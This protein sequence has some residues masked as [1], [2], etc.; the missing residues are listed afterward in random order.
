MAENTQSVF[1]QHAFSGLTLCAIIKNHQDMFDDL[2]SSISTILNERIVSPLFGTLFFTWSVWNWKIIYFTLF[3]SEEKFKEDKITYITSNF[4]EPEFL[5]IYPIIS[6]VIILTIIPFISNGTYWLSLLFNRWRVNKKNEVLKSQL[7]TL[8]Q[9]IALREEINKREK[10]FEEL[11]EDKNSQI[12]IL[13]LELNTLKNSPTLKEDNLV[14][15]KEESKSLHEREENT[16]IV[17]LAYKIKRDNSLFATFEKLSYLIQR[18]YRLNDIGDAPSTSQVNYFIGN[19]MIETDEQAR[20]SFT[21]YGKKV[22]K[23]IYDITE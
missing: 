11:V 1:S 10:R 19:N 20:F 21:E 6:T 22:A 9:S 2:K 17:D 3:V 13:E 23:A 12:K 14:V 8:E 15:S 5:Y 16:L 7:L 18:R 4:Y